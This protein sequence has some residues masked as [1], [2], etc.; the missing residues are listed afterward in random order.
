MCSTILLMLVVVFFFVENQHVYLFVWFNKKPLGCYR[1]VSFLFFYF[2]SFFHSHPH[3]FSLSATCATSVVRFNLFRYR[4][5]LHF[6]FACFA[7]C[8]FWSFPECFHMLV[9][10]GMTPSVFKLNTHAFFLHCNH[11]HPHPHASLEK[12]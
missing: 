9:A 2:P 3:S 11:P 12:P 7:V 1:S 8:S 5:L 6:C 10:N 4:L